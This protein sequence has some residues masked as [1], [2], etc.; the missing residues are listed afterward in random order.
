MNS[1]AVFN[2]NIEFLNKIYPDIA[3]FAQMAGYEKK[4]EFLTAKTGN[5]TVK[6]DDILLHSL[7]DPKKEAERFV[8]GNNIREGDC[9]FLYG[10]GL[11]YHVGEIARRIG[12]YG[13][14]VI[15]ELNPDILKAALSVMDLQAVFQQ[16][17]ASLVFAVSEYELN[18]KI[19]E[20]I[21]SYKTEI[22][23]TVIHPT[24]FK[25]IPAGFKNLSLFLESKLTNTRTK[26]VFKK[27]YFENIR[28]NI[29]VVLSSP[30]INLFRRK[31]L[32]KP[33]IMAGAGPSLDDNIRIIRKLQKNVFI[34]VVDTAY[35]IFIENGI[36]P[37]FAVTVDPQPKTMAHFRTEPEYGIPLIISPVSCSCAVKKHKGGFIVF[38]QKDHSATKQIEK[39]LSDKGFSYEG[40]SV[41]CIALDIMLQFGFDPIVFAGMDFAYPFMKAY[42]ANSMEGNLISQNSGRFNNIDTLHRKRI[43]SEQ[44]V[45]DISNSNEIKVVTSPNLMGYKKN[46]ENLVEINRQ[47]VTF[48]SFAEYGARIKG[49]K[50][51][52]EYQAEK[53]FYSELDKKFSVPE[54]KA[55]PDLRKNILTAING[56]EN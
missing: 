49:V 31:F 26:E 28:A 11:G 41:S 51:I 14:L 53:F 24:S 8:E 18:R 56:L 39:F 27:F 54:I 40:G 2:S 12:M 38:L 44:T 9:V 19:Q 55:D 29:D 37:D 33:L 4:T 52:S 5:L 34:A 36:K 6:Y 20:E 50:L 22:V 7:F 10:C 42:S 17:R 3:L 21:P 30:G 43:F 25:C 13:R 15:I 46:I 16:C 23:K 45:L 47:K 1:C 48:Y 32:K 35:P